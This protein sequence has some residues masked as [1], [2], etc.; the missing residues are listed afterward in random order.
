MNLFMGRGGSCEHEQVNDPYRLAQELHHGVVR[1]PPEDDLTVGQRIAELRRREGRRRGERLTQQA[2]AD[3][4]GVHKGTVAAWEGD[5][6]Q[7]DGQN[8]IKLAGALRTS[9]EAILDEA[10]VETVDPPFWSGRDHQVGEFHM[11][12]LTSQEAL[13]QTLTTFGGPGEA[14]EDKLALLELLSKVAAR[15]R[16]EGRDVS[17]QAITQ[18]QGHVI[19]GTL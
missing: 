13:Y 19:D 9:P 12:V 11:S 7:P 3:E 18:A 15:L 6:Q 5:T 1:L 16:R 10:S 17:P 2:L 4:V 14:V 8:L